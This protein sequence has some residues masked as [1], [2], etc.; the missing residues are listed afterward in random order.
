MN[1]LRC[2]KPPAGHLGTLQPPVHFLSTSA[3]RS[4]ALQL[5][6]AYDLDDDEEYAEVYEETDS[7]VDQTGMLEGW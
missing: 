2:H 4:G 3:C 7:P 1:N 5:T 6:P